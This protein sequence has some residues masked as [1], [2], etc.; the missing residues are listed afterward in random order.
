MYGIH[1]VRESLNF[2]SSA[3]Q[4]YIFSC[5]K[6]KS[7]T[8]SK[9][10]KKHMHTLETTF[11]CCSFYYFVCCFR[12]VCVC[13]FLSRPLLTSFVCYNSLDLKANL[14]GLI[15]QNPSTFCFPSITS[16]SV[17]FLTL[18]LMGLVKERPKKNEFE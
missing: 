10:R 13:V 8:T 12:C 11:M 9:E 1:C 17:P 7:M 16:A 4:P 18:Y 5:R 6:E 15:A 2:P 14:T 3:H